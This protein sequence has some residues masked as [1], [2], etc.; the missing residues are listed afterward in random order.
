[1]SLNLYPT[2]T[3]YV[4]NA[5]IHIQNKKKPNRRF[6][7]ISIICSFISRHFWLIGQMFYLLSDCLLIIESSLF[8]I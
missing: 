4:I 3:I 8:Y 6:I 2:G 5:E 7:Y 1:M